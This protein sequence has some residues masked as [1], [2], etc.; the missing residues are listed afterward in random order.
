[1]EERAFEGLLLLPADPKADG[2]KLPLSSLAAVVYQLPADRHRRDVLVH[3]CF[4]VGC[5]SHRAAGV[6]V[7]PLP[8]GRQLAGHPAASQA[9]PRAVAST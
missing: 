6:N 7:T 1:M 3:L 8:P 5:D 9:I 2:L 4:I